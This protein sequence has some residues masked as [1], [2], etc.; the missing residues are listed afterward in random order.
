MN[1]LQGFS[2]NAE[3]S[4][5]T[6]NNYVTK[7]MSLMLKSHVN[8]LINKHISQITIFINIRRDSIF[9]CKKKLFKTSNMLF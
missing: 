2:A 4:D 5:G 9:F 7:E 1:T 3:I 6:A 8:T